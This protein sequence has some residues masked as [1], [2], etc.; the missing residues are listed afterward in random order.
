MLLRDSDAAHCG[1]PPDGLHRMQ[2]VVHIALVARSRAPR[3]PGQVLAKAMRVA[4]ERQG[5]AGRQLGEC[6]PHA[7]NAPGARIA[8]GKHG[9]RN[10]DAKHLTEVCLE[11][12]LDLTLELERGAHERLRLVGA[13]LDEVLWL[14]S[15]GWGAFLDEGDLFVGET[16]EV[17][18]ETVQLRIER[19]DFAFEQ[20]QAVTNRAGALRP[21]VLCP[22]DY[23]LD[24]PGQSLI[25]G[26]VTSRQPDGQVL[27]V[28]LVR[29]E[30]AAA[31]VCC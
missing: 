1:R 21:E 23:L 31:E 25:R 22:F 19:R 11:P 30:I 28:L 16:V 7:V 9:Q 29:G 13:H 15:G 18:D 17:V 10:A 2:G 24:L 3:P 12:P 26:A 8:V 4:A 20:C 5:R 27:D 14:V 6:Y